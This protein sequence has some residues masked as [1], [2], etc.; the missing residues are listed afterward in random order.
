M[1]RARILALIGLAVGLAACGGNAQPLL[2]T[3]QP[4][5]RT[6]V[7]SPAPTVVA[8]VPTYAT[9]MPLPTRLPLTATA[10]PSPTSPVAATMTPAPAT[11]T[12]TRAPTLAGLSVEYFTTDAEF[13]K[14]GENVTL[15]WSV[16]GADRVQI[17]RVDAEGERQWRWD[18]NLT[19][20]LT[21]STPVEERDVARFVLVGESAG[22]TVEQPLLIPLRCPEVW[23]F[24]PAPDSCPASPPKI[25]GQAEQSFERGRMIWVGDLD[26]I[27]VVFDDGGSPGWAQYPDNFV[28]GDPERDDALVPPADLLQPVRGFGLVWRTNTRVQERLGWA[29]L[30]EVGFDGMYQADNAEL[31]VATIY[32]RTRDSG[33]LALDAET[34]EW[35]Y[36]PLVESGD[37]TS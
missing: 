26:R 21:V 13:I 20:K 33:I 9:A 16:R 17:F 36:L 8:A 4:P 11:L 23:F 15:F 29:T 7:P 12:A 3:F 35:D 32:L 24:D 5:T 31:S 14:P 28:E 25:T 30:P 27:Y 10:G 6:A 2:V 1:A 34:N 22:S 19:G 37:T 18:V